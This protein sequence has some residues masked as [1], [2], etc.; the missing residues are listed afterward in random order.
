VTRSCEAVGLGLGTS[1][2][3]P[4]GWH[5]QAQVDPGEREDVT[6]EEMPISSR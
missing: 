3:T 2:E 6:S 1:N 5:R 4:H